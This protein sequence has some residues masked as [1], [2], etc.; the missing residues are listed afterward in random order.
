MDEVLCWTS[1]DPRTSILFGGTGNVQFRFTT[2]RTSTPLL[3]YSSYDVVQDMDPVNATTTTTLWKVN[4]PTREDRLA[5]FE[6]ALNGSLGRATLG[7]TLGRVC[8]RSRDRWW[9]PPSSSLSLT[10]NLDAL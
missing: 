2:V 3:C 5:K 7:A 10:W 8:M 6:W 9:L 4:R 1:P